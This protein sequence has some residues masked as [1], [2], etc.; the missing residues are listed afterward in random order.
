MNCNSFGTAICGFCQAPLVEGEEREC[1]VGEV[2]LPPISPAEAAAIAP[3]VDDQ[4]LL[5][6]YVASALE[7]IGVPPCHACK[8]RRDWLNKAHLW[9]REKFGVKRNER[10]APYSLDDVTIIVTSFLR[11]DC[12]RRFLTSARFYY[13]GVKIIVADQSGD[14]VQ[15]NDDAAFCHK[16]P[17]VKWLDLP[18]DCGLS[19]SRNAAVLATETSLVFVSDDDEIF[20]DESRIEALLDVLNSDP[21]IELISGLLRQDGRGFKADTACSWSADLY[22]TGGTLHAESPNRPWRQAA[23][24][25]WYRPCDRFLNI[26]LCRRQLLLDHPWNERHKI[27]GEHLDHVLKLK[28]AGKQAAY[29]PGFVLGENK[30]TTADYS[31]F[32]K[33]GQEAAAHADWGIKRKTGEQRIRPER[34][35]TKR[36]TIIPQIE[37]PC[38]VLLTAGNTGSTQCAGLLSLFGWHLP[39]NDDRFNE[40]TTVRAAN[41]AI[42]DADC[43][44]IL[45]SLPKPWL[46]KD[47][48]FCNTLERW[49]PALTKFKPTLLWLQRD[50]ARTCDSWK[51]RNQRTEVLDSRLTNAQRHYDYWPWAKAIV[52]FEDVTAWAKAFSPERAMQIA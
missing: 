32:R 7:A 49:M 9:L 15:G 36:D 10:L 28:T 8:E 20:S 16:M 26:F 29:T 39:D 1:P 47:P 33:R 2:K 37:L 51:R 52:K 12:L 35:V 45:D 18:F 40:P 4:T 46:I 42:S 34:G 11:F 17:G 22:L 5:G 30:K 48:R 21:T 3:G 19:A 41:D 25:T 31:P 44:A 38:V 27:S 6:N 43:A 23:G 14:A 13:P 24:A 50:Y